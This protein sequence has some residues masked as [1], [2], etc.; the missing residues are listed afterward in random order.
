MSKCIK[1]AWDRFCDRPI[2]KRNKYVIIDPSEPIAQMTSKLTEL[3]PEPFQSLSCRFQFFLEAFD[4]SIELA[5]AFACRFCGRGEVF[6]CASIGTAYASAGS[7]ASTASGSTCCLV[8]S[9]FNLSNLIK[10][11]Q[12]TLELLDRLCRFLGRS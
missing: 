4:N 6:H 3:F 10:A 9:L 5:H 12:R 1:K 8:G 7:T 11:F 2:R